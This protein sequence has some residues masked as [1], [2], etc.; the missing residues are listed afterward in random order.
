MK[1]IVQTTNAPAAI[2][3]YSQAIHANGLVF[4]SGQLGIDPKTSELVP[5]GLEPETRQ[6]LMNLKA[7]LE[8]AGAAP[9]DVVKTTV[10]ILDMADFAK[11]NQ[12]YGEVF[13]AEPPARSC[14]AVSA[15]PKGGK[16]EIEAIAAPSK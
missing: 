11:V 8:A 12:I 6:S 10:F 16:V 4:V 2:G 7:I 15:L 9:A 13:D 3:P 14:V 5:G 1:S